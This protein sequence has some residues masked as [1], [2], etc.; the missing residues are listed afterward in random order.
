MPWAGHDL[1]GYLSGAWNS[2]CEVRFERDFMGR[3][4]RETQGDFTIESRYNA[5]GARTWMG[6]SRGLEVSYEFDADRRF[7]RLLTHSGHD[8]SC[9]RDPMGREAAL[10]F[11]G[12]A[13][14]EQGWDLRG[15]MASQE[16]A[17]PGFDPPS[18]AWAS[19]SLRSRRTRC[20]ARRGWGRCSSAVGNPR[21]RSSR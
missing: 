13:T 2:T 7:T 19:T 16:M 5:L 10:V 6:T 21:S 12:G 4:V 17:Q 18:V 14:L 15:R 3:I 20:T 1:L 11:P 9:R 8:I